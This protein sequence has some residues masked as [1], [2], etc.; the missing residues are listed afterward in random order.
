MRTGTQKAGP[1]ALRT[2]E[3]QLQALD[4]RRKGGTYAQIAQTMGVV[5]ATAFNLVQ[6]ALITTIQE[7]SDAVRA[8]EMER[9][10]FLTQKLEARIQAGEDK[11]INT[12]LKVMDHRARLLG[13]FAPVT[14]Q[15]PDG[16]AIKFVVEI[17][18]KA[19]TL[20]DW[21]AQAAAVIDGEVVNG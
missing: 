5:K 8:L 21:Q 12:L 13:L 7:P 11:A 17:P 1:K 20:A 15:G 2:H 10:D 4:L 18:A 14:I 19:P 9:L 3:R 16:E 6:E